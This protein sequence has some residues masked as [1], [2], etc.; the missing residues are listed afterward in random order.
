M[1]RANH[2]AVQLL[3]YSSYLTLT[4]QTFFFSSCSPTAFSSLLSTG[5]HQ[6]AGGLPLLI[7]LSP[8]KPCHSLRVMF[9]A[10]KAMITCRKKCTLEKVGFHWFQPTSLQAHHSPCM[11][12]PFSFVRLFIFRF[13][14]FLFLFFSSCVRAFLL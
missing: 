4:L 6:G 8:G 12:S 9:V 2:C 3:N 10:R 5:V 1:T 14:F 13:L 11:W 7:C